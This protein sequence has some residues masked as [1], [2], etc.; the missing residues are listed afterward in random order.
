MRS[1]GIVSR[2]CPRRWPQ[3]R[4]FPTLRK[5]RLDGGRLA[6]GASLWHSNATLIRWRGKLLLA[7][8][9]GWSKSEVWW[10]E[11]HGPDYL[12]GQS[13]KLNLTH[14]HA[15]LGREDPRFFIHRDRLHV[16]FAG[17]EGPQGPCSQ[18]YARLT[19]DLRVERVFY[20]DY[21]RRDV[22]MK[23]ISLFSHDG[24]LYAVD[25]ISPH[26]VL[27]VDDQ[28]RAEDAYQTANVRPWLGGVLRVGSSPFRVGDE[29]VAWFHGKLVTAGVAR[30]SCGV[31]RFR[32]EP[33]FEVTYQTPEPLAWGDMATR[34]Q[35]WFANWFVCGAILEDGKWI[36]SGGVHDRNIEIWEYPEGIV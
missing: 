1:A 10:C 26:C 21:P 13:T 6:G 19:D 20:L 14:A 3:R 34:P 17:V 4:P 7:Y 18:L 5:V 30:Y 15:K 36:V 32:A 12:P 33:P 23:N 31:Y 11:L 24:Q 9:V 28:G 2:A 29:Y 22:W 8:R 25:R 16:A 27:R 35:G